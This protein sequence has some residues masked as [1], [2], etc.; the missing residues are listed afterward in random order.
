MFCKENYNC[1]KRSFRTL[2]LVNFNPR[3]NLTPQKS[4]RSEILLH[5]GSFQ[6]IFVSGIE[7]SAIG[8]VKEI[9]N[10]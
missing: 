3:L 10:Y 2:Q 5:I 1:I 4:I 8:T 9:Y 6:I 7:V